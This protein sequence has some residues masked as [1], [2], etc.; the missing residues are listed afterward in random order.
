M[1]GLGI[2]LAVLVYLLSVIVGYILIFRD[3]YDGIELIF[4]IFDEFSFVIA[5]IGPV[6][7]LIGIVDYFRDNPITVD[8]Y[9]LLNKFKTKNEIKQ[10]F[11][12]S[13]P[14][15]IDLSK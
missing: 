9:H 3:I 8:I 12:N 15:I 10:Q 4:K 7:C 11:E 6:A 5:I 1:T 14:I 13:G 2:Y